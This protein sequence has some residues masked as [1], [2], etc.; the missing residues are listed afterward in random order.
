MTIFGLAIGGVVSVPATKESMSTC[1]QMAHVQ[2]NVEQLLQRF[3]ALEEVPGED[4]SLSKEEQL[5]IAHFRETHRRQ[6]DG[7][8]VV[9]LPKREPRLVLGKSRDTAL[10][11]YITNERS[12]KRKG[13]WD[14]FHQGIQ[15]YLRMG[16]AEIVP[17]QEL[18]KMPS[19]TFY[20][21]M[22]G[23][24]KEST[25]TKLRI[26]FDGSAKSSTGHSLNDTLLTGPSLYP[27]LT[28]VIN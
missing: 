23:V 2:E 19:D 15:E 21:P 14:S 24:V 3:W 25:M 1:L 16:H 12:L 9:G 20:L 6:P 13:Q 27:L 11:R 10:R 18:I 7:R 28:T 5:A 8:Y 4:C 22:H 26:I 17:Q